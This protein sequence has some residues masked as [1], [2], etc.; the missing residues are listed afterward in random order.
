M[1]E[2]LG[3]PDSVAN[4]SP[5]SATEDWIYGAV[6]AEKYAATGIVSVDRDYKTVLKVA[7]PDRFAEPGRNAEHLVRN[8]AQPVPFAEGIT[9]EIKS[10][11]VVCDYDVPP[12][13]DLGVVIRNGG[14]TAFTID[15]NWMDS[16]SVEVINND[17]ISMLRDLARLPD[18]GCLSS[19]FLTM[20]VGDLGNM[21]DKLTTVHWTMSCD[22]FMIDQVFSFRQPMSP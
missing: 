19:L 15:P 8:D 7:T 11:N 20:P 4:V 3:K 1:L 12:I 9:C 10:C 16:L 13:V 14:S 18:S 5:Y 2:L 6:G 21:Y 22:L 17:G